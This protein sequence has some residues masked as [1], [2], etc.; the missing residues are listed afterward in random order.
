LN[1]SLRN[2]RPGR[3]GFTVIEVIVSSAVLVIGC[4]GLASAVTSGA[5]LM[6]LNRER[7]LAHEG[8]RAELEV[9]E[10]ADFDQVFALFN[11]SQA[12]DPAGAGTAPGRDFAVAGLNARGND[13]D[14]LPGEVIFPTVGDNGLQLDESYVDGR[15]GMPRD[16]SGDGIASAGALVGNYVVLPVRVRVRWRGPSGNSTLEIDT[17]L[18][19]RSQ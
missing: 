16:L 11:A 6:E 7:A 14:G 1:L 13:A 4:L 2:K 3:S 8:A 10:N 5:R 18:L 19:D 12:D 17:V 15:W 9:L